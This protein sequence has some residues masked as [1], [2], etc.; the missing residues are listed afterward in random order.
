MDLVPG[1]IRRRWC[2]QLLLLLTRIHPRFQLHDRLFQ[3]SGITA[4]KGCNVIF[5]VGK[6][7]RRGYHREGKGCLPHALSGTPEAQ[8]G[9]LDRRRSKA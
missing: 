8:D 9:S 6:R 1:V 7:I 3:R 5:R 2:S 4:K